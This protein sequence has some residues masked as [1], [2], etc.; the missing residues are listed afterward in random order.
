MS[1]PILYMIAVDF[2]LYHL[3]LLR[4]HFVVLISENLSWDSDSSALHI[5]GVPEILQI[6]LRIVG[7]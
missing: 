1:D 6:F 7:K 3:E 2:I 5:E 4:P